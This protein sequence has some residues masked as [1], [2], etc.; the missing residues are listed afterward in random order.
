MGGL[1]EFASDHGL[2]SSQQAYRI[3]G[4]ENIQFAPASSPNGPCVSDHWQGHLQ[5]RPLWPHPAR[6]DHLPQ[7]ADDGRKPWREIHAWV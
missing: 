5:S 6:K 4:W 2:K 3:A 7:L 1:P